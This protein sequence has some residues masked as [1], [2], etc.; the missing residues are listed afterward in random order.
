MAYDSLKWACIVT[1]T[2]I[3]PTSQPT[4]P[5]TLESTHRYNIDPR[6]LR[7]TIRE[8]ELLIRHP[9]AKEITNINRLIVTRPNNVT[10]Q[11]LNLEL[12]RLREELHGH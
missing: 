9:D 5:H 7:A 3:N 4:T 6:D 1:T 11:H 8:V 10:L 12:Q 2:P